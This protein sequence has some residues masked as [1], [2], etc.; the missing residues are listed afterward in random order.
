MKKLC[1][2]LLLGGAFFTLPVMAQEEEDV[3]D[4]IANAGFDE[5]LTFQADGAMKPIISTTTSLGDGSRSWAYIAEDNTVYAKPK[6]TSSQSRK[7]GRKLEAVNGFRGE[8]QGWTLVTGAE[9]PACEWTYFGTIPYN[10]ANQAIPIADDGTTY[11]EVPAKPAEFDTEDN[12][13]FAYLR[14]GW[15]GRAVYKQTV[16]LPCAQYRL[17]YWSINLNPNGKNGTNLSKVTCRKTTWPDETG[18]SA[19]DWTQHVIEFTPSSEFT[20]EFG[21][22]SSGG[23]GSNPFLCI[24]GIKLYK[25]GEADQNAILKEDLYEYADEAIYLAQDSL[26][27]NFGQANE[28]MYD[29]IAIL[30]DEIEALIDNEGDIDEINA[31]MAELRGFTTEIRDLVASGNKAMAIYQYIQDKVL[32]YYQEIPGYQSLNAYCDNIDLS[33]V[34]AEEL[35][36]LADKMEEELAKFWLSQNGTRENPAIYT[37]L[38]QAPWFSKPYTEPANRESVA[39][40]GQTDADLFKG[41]WVVGSQ[42]GSEHK[43]YFA[44]D[45]TAF[46]L[47]NTNFS[48]YLDVHQELTDIPN[49]IYSLQADLITN[50]NARSDQH[51]YATSALQETLGYMTD[52]AAYESWQSGT[53]PED[54]KDYWETVTTAETVIVTDGKLTIGARS[55]QKHYNTDTG[56]YDEAPDMSSGGR[57]GSFWMTNFILRYHGAATA[58][59]IA[60]AT[61]ARLQKANDLKD[62][63]NFAA[64]KASVADSIAKFNS[65]QD[66]NALNGG[67]ALAEKSEAKYAEIMEEGKTI[68]TVRDSL[69]NEQGE[70]YGPAYDIVKHA[71][72][73][74]VAW[75]ASQEATYS[76]ADSILNVMKGYT[77]TYSAAYCNASEK[78]NKL[79][80]E[81]GKT[82]LSSLMTEQKAALLVEPLLT[83]EAVNKL[84]ADL[85]NV[86]EVVEAQDYYEQHQDATDYTSYIKNSKS[87]ATDGWTI[88][89]KGDGPIKDGQYM[90]DGAHKYFDSWKADGA[91][92]FTMEQVIKNLPNGTYQLTAAMRAPSEGICLFTANGGEA[93]TDTTYVDV[94]LD[95]YMGVDEEEQPVQLIASD[96]H[97]PIWSAIDQKQAEQGFSSLTDEE[98]AI[99]N[100]NPD[101]LGQGQGRGWKW[102][103]A[104]AVV[105][106]HTLVI[107]FTNNP[108]RT[109]KACTAQWYSATDFSLTLLEKGDNTGWDGPITGIDETPAEQRTA[110]IDGIYTLSGARVQKAQRG[111]YIIVQGGKSRK[112]IIK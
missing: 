30:Q 27:E 72:D 110:A 14:A 10:L 7:D 26:A 19:T 6:S 29:K 46:Q 69:N 100:A 57:R 59:E 103:T 2:L 41:T 8:V 106:N 68:P 88:I 99:W 78:L 67:I 60:E 83:P 47:W 22:E 4:Y 23:S 5:D 3:T 9:F 51:I 54:A 31:K 108:E 85:K 24:D 104:T 77:N 55:T 43:L 111:L 15:G 39:E 82:A 73:N 48:G 107:G 93:K 40:A 36:T 86:I 1:T 76:K 84:V 25:I 58:E 61:A 12:I 75:I 80:S 81:K 20:M 44:Y 90:D 11:L 32:P 112:V 91:V 105:A 33:K 64:D 56:Q 35:P 66:L 87:E 28:D 65:E 21:F 50:A 109:G 45:R 95:Y 102:V 53:M 96:S 98:Q 42:S 79:S 70:K 92:L 63:M 16:K 34:S 17:E 71:Y 18:F 52:V 97:G 13:G 49:G 94:P 38:V 74:T 37:F 89:D 62:A 101:A